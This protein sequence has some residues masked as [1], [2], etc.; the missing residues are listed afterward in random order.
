MYTGKI[1]QIDIDV[2]PVIEVNREA[3]LFVH[4]FDTDNSVY[5]G[6][7]NI[8]FTSSD[9]KTDVSY[10]ESAPHRIPYH[11]LYQYANTYTVQI[12]AMN[13]VSVMNKSISIEVVCKLLY[14]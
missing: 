8:T 11:L 5:S 6:T 2:N 3:K 9:D 12:I 14:W 7:V 4:L 1:G 13:E 10:F